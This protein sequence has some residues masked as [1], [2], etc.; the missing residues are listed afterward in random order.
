MSIS[1][2]VFIKSLCFLYIDCGTNS[3]MCKKKGSV[4]V[5][6]VNSTLVYR[7]GF[8]YLHYKNGDD[9]QGFPG[10]KMETFITFVCDPTKGTGTPKLERTNDCTHF[11]T[12][13]TA[14]AC[15]AEVRS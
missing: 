11:V 3:G 10:R 14:L 12:W 15:E 7:Q 5:G 1:S 4:N 13:K 6:S 9:C 2:A 8:L